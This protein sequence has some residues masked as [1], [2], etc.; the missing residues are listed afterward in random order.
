M[1]V[2]KIVFAIGLVLLLGGVIARCANTDYLGL[3]AL[4]SGLLALALTIWADEFRASTDDKLDEI[5]VLLEK[6][7]TLATPA[8]GRASFT[9]GALAL[10]VVIFAA[11]Q[12]CRDCR[13]KA[14]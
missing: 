3:T 4:Y 10:A 9:T 6:E 5:K 1:A 7:K 2:G 13:R 12:L 11:A 8:K 14:D